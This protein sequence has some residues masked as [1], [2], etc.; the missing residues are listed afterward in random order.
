MLC[1]EQLGIA[2]EEK[3]LKW[4]PNRGSTD[5][6]CCSIREGSHRDRHT[7]VFH[8]LRGKFS[9][10]QCFLYCLSP[11]CLSRCLYLESLVF[12][13]SVSL[14]ILLITILFIKMPIF[15]KFFFHNVWIEHISYDSPEP[16]SLWGPRRRQ[17]CPCTELSQT[18]RPH[19]KSNIKIV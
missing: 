16:L 19:L 8:R 1:I 15:R 2:F 14:P 9:F 6:E 18:C 13:H 17:D 4:K 12:F 5:K 10:S 7:R 3:V 11:Y